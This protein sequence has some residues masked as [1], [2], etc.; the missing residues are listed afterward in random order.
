MAAGVPYT[1]YAFWESQLMSP[2]GMMLLVPVRHIAVAARLAAAILT[3]SP[4]LPAQVI[5][6]SIPT[7]P[8]PISGPAVFDTLGN[9]STTSA[10]QLPQGLLKLSPE[11]GPAR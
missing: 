8:L 1:R 9:T 11:A 5:P 10:G 4:A 7:I 6:P 2:V 3:I